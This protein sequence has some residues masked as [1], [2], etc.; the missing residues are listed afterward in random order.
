MKITE[1]N[2][3]EQLKQQNE[4]ALIYVVNEYGG[5]LS[6]VIR[7]H[8]HL[9]HEYQEECLNDVFWGIWNHI[10]AF[11]PDRSSFKNWIAA[12]ARYKAI[13]YLRKHYRQIVYEELDSLKISEPDVALEAITAQEI[14]DE[15]AQM[16]SCLNETDKELF[17]KLYLEDKDVDEVSCETG[18]KKEVIYNR[19]SRAK[20]RIKQ[21]YQEV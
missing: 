4:K 18:L 5:F 1:N 17:L 14:S 20:K 9:L 12:I 19:L 8:L 3:I 21:S 13:D 11:Q 10:S 6:S 7:R 15:L 2:F 16:L